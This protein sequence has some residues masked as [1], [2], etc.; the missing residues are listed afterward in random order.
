MLGFQSN[1]GQAGQIFFSSVGQGYDPSRSTAVN[2]EGVQL[3][4]MQQQNLA[5]QLNFQGGQNN[6]DRLFQG[7]QND[8]NR[9]FQGQQSQ[10]DRTFQGGQNDANRALQLQLGMAPIDF[11]K[12][13]FNTVMPLIQGLLGGGG[14]G[15]GS[16][17]GALGAFGAVPQVSAGGIYSSKDMQNQV[18]AQQAKNAQQETAQNRQASAETAGQGFGTR[19]PLLAALQQGFAMNRQAQDATA[20]REI[21]LQYQ[22]ANAD[23]IQKGQMANQQAA[24]QGQANQ[25]AAAN[26]QRTYTTGLLGALAGL[27]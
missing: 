10:L 18:N 20:S 6:L 27:L 13:K 22:Q 7:T 19:S 14:G 24:L 23:N 17:P 12:E 2:S 11:A 25:V 4:L 16:S 5:K 1:P 15:G 9:A 26:S 8:A 21:P 3:G